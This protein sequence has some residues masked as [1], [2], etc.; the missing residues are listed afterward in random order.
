[1]ALF[2]ASLDAFMELSPVVLS[3]RWRLSLNRSSG[4]SQGTRMT[5]TISTMIR[6]RHADAHEV[7][8]GVVA[9][10]TTSVFTGDETG[11]MK[12]VEAASATI[13]AKG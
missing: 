11:V 10:A 13:I 7:A 9:G 3:C 12:A 8:E 1:M 5:Q 4:S 2:G 6:K